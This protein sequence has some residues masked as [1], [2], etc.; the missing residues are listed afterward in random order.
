MTVNEFRA[1]AWVFETPDDA[2]GELPENVAAALSGA[3][4]FFDEVGDW[5]AAEREIQRNNLLEK[6]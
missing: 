1:L 4:R 6:R 5:S 3:D 2:V